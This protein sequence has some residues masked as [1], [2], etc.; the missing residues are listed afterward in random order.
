LKDLFLNPI[1]KSVW[2]KIGKS[3]VDERRRLMEEKLRKHAL[4]FASNRG[5]SLFVCLLLFVCCFTAPLHN[6]DIGA[7]NGT[8]RKTVE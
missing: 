1:F 7:N 3:D 4:E 6:L 8:L 5:F 2:E